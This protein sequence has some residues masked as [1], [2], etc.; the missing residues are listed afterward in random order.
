[1]FQTSGK[2]GCPSLPLVSPSA[3]GA[4]GTETRGGSEEDAE[5]ELGGLT[6]LPVKLS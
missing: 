2:S 3:P 6:A 4:K 1:M 5:G